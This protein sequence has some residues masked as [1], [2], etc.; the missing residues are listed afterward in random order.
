LSF[1]WQVENVANFK[2]RAESHFAILL[3]VDGL[4]MLLA[5]LAEHSHKIRRRLLPPWGAWQT[6]I[7]AQLQVSVHVLSTI[8]GQ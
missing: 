2:G 6:L 8:L 5:R 3:Q 4:L 1:S 7:T